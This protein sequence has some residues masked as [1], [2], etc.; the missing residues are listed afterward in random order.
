[1]L[2]SGWVRTCSTRPPPWCAWKLAVH[3]VRWLL[4]RPRKT[5]VKHTE[6]W[7]SSTKENTH[8]C[9]NLGPS[10]SPPPNRLPAPATESPSWCPGWAGPARSTVLSP[11]RSWAGRLTVRSRSGDH[12]TL[13]RGQLMDGT[14]GW[15]R[16]AVPTARFHVK[17]KPIRRPMP[18]IHLPKPR[19]N[20]TPRSR[21]PRIRNLKRGP[22]RR[23]APILR[24]HP[25]LS[26]LVSGLPETW[27]PGLPPPRTPPRRWRARSS[28]TSWADTTLPHSRGRFGPE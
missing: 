16:L 20:R 21:T 14:G 7:L 8:P 27:R 5:A 15:R 13:G 18:Q 1:L 22:F 19:R 11:T 12:R 23:L 25:Q 3:L 26:P 6:I 9:R 28:T 10:P 2:Y 4:S 24:R 17:P